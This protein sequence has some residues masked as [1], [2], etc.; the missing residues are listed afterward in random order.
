MA[1][2]AVHAQLNVTLKSYYRKKGRFW[3]TRG[4][5]Q[6]LPYVCGDGDNKSGGN[7]QSSSGGPVKTLR[8]ARSDWRFH[9]DKPVSLRTPV[10]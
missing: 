7:Y 4:G 1:T 10:Y 2:V 3:Q 9:G 6:L 8:R 5:G